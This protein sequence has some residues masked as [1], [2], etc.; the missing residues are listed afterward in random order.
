M[1]KYIWS[2][3]VVT[4][5]LLS[6]CGTSQ[7]DLDATATQI[8]AEIFATQT[9]QA[10]TATPTFTPTPTPTDTPTL[11]PTPTPT[12]T[13]S[14][15]PTPTPTPTPPPTDT[16]TP[17]PPVAIDIPEGWVLYIAGDLALA[18]P[19]RWQ[20]IDVTEEGVEAI[21]DTASALNEEWAQNL[22]AMFSAEAMKDKLKF[23]ALDPKL[24]GSG[25]ATVN[26]TQDAM[27]FALD[28][29]TL[30][31]QLES[32]Y[33]QMGLTVLAVEKDL[34]INGLDAARATIEAGVG[35][36]TVRQDQY[37][38]VQDTDIW[39]LTLAVD[40]TAWEDYEPTF[41]TIAQTFHLP[42]APPMP[43]S[44][45][46]EPLARVSL[47]TDEGGMFGNAFAEMSWAGVERA[48]AELGIEGDYLESTDPGDYERNIEAFLEE[49]YDIIVT[50]SILMAE[51]TLNAAETHPQTRFILADWTL[52]EPRDN[53]IGT[54]FATDE[55]AFLAGY[56]AAGMSETGKVGV[57]G[58]MKIPPVTQYLVGFEQGVAYYNQ[59]HDAQV[60]V[61]GWTT[62]AEQEGC[63]EGLFVNNFSDR[64]LGQET[65]RSLLEQGAD[66]IFPMAG[67]L[68]YGAAAACQEAGAKLVGVDTDWYTSL[69]EYR[70][71]YLTSAT[72]NLDVMVY[73]GIR[74]ALEAPFLG[75]FLTGTLENGG[76]SLAPFHDFEDQIPATL[77]TE[78]EAVREGIVEGTISTG[79]AE[80]TSP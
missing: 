53:V 66:V 25:F 4:A 35:P 5:L 8:A 54:V 40:Q 58:G 19:E 65:A 56:L 17:T 18:L 20:A 21:F 15:T 43:A 75:G 63:G 37:I 2:L 34:E 70:E 23:W 62:D 52:D 38:L 72:K 59:A 3:L 67:G 51:D 26:V 9:A 55:A 42:A 11:T 12:D 29:E 78:L 60:Q 47:V 57:F 14:P 13:P 36:F 41:A 48:V 46:P 7:E 30:A 76:V 73:E 24:A 22:T 10:P 79:W 39:I 77:L 61:L 28:A 1:K 6:A 49:G 64:D 80:C 68:G 31:G 45:T 50:V 27:P 16:P 74:L 71:V 32:V 44:P 33:E 69:P